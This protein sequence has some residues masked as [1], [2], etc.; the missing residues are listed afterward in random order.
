MVPYTGHSL[1]YLIDSFQISLTDCCH[2]SISRPYLKVMHITSLYPI[3][4]HKTAG[5]ELKG[6]TSMSVLFLC[7]LFWTNGPTGISRM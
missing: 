5:S 6:L 4:F 1:L 7:D 2:C 3:M